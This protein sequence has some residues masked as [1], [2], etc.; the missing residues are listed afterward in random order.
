MFLLLSY[1][2]CL[3]SVGR[4][5]LDGALVALD[6]PS[7]ESSHYTWEDF[8]VLL[9]QRLGGAVYKKGLSRMFLDTWYITVVSTPSLG[10]QGEKCIL[11]VNSCRTV[12][13]KEPGLPR[14]G[15]G[16]SEAQC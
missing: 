16:G 9:G 5:R 11:K 2:V 3:F 8:L 7:A 10:I 13:A 1:P 6:T 4:D 14:Q 12:H 15:G